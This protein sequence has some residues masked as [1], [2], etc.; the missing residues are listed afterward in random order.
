MRIDISDEKYWKSMNYHD[1][2]LYLSLLTIDD[3]EGWRMPT[4]IEL[5]GIESCQLVDNLIR[6][7]WVSDWGYYKDYL[8]RIHM[9]VPVRDL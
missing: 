3:V 9:I 7:F 4:L 8:D 5:C 6:N 2:L 1:G